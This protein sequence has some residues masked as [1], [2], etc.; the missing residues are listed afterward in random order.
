MEL[1]G[2]DPFIIRSDADV[3]FAVELLVN[4][5]MSNCG[6]ICFSPKRIIVHSSV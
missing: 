4:G 5:R 1:G 2:S 3:D 6:Q